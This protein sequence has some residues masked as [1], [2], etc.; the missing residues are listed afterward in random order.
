MAGFYNEILHCA[1][2]DFRQTGQPTAQVTTDGQVLLGATAAPNIRAGTLTSTGG[3]ITITYV[4]GTNP[5]LNFETT[6]GQS[7]TNFDVDAHTG[8][9]TDPVVPN[10]SG[11]V[12]ITGGQTAPGT[13]ANIIQTNSLAANTYTIQ[14]QQTSS[15]AAKDTTKNGVSHFDSAFFTNDQGFISALGSGFIQKVNLQ[16]GTTPITPTA[17]AIT[18]NGAVVS[19]GTNPIRTDGT[20]VSTA[21]IEVQITQALAATDATKIGLANFDSAAFDVDANGFVQLN[22]GG[23]AVTSFNV[24]AHTVPGTDPV[25]PDATGQVT[26]TGGQTAPGTISNVIQTNSLAA[27]TWTTQIQQTSAVA[28]KDTTKNGVAHFNS[29]QFTNDQ[30]FISII[31]GG[32]FTWSDIGGAFN[33][34]VFNG[35]FVEAAATATMPASPSEGDRIQ[36]I[37]DTTAALVITANTGQKIRI[38]NQISSTAGTFTS[39]LQGDAV[40]LVYRTSGATW[41]ADSSPCGTWLP[42]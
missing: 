12:I 39:T 10:A 19:A 18:L 2:V 31:P 9:G 25:V 24:D 38:A 11:T 14:I 29:A 32:T 15:V 34:A 1:N 6:G 16:T 7:V 4:A 17:G 42:A 35:Y 5:S 41:I 28:A 26:V 20:G 33:A 23:I 8:P 13:I 27:N 21:A 3:T 36:F 40:N 22:G 30:G 37:V